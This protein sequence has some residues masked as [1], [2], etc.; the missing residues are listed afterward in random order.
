MD[1]KFNEFQELSIN[2]LTEING[3]MS[4]KTR[5]I[6]IALCF[7]SPIAGA[8]YFLAYYVNS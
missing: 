2:E 5:N 7:I 6:G 1:K 4:A 8:G 3:G